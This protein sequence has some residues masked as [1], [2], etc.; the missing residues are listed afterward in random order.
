M[1]YLLAAID[2]ER[3]SHAP[4]LST[5]NDRLKFCPYVLKQLAL[6][7][8]LFLQNWRGTSYLLITKIRG[9]LQCSL[10]FRADDMRR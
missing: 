7:E 9:G 1:Q 6:I 5:E 2:R 3:R 4:V 8:H 10:D